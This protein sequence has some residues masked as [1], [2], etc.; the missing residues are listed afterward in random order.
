MI[1]FIL[2]IALVLIAFT[3]TPKKKKKS[4]IERED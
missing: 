1:N 3:D 2:A 4:T